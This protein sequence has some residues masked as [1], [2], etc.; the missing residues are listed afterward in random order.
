[1]GDFNSTFLSGRI[2]SVPVAGKTKKGI[3]AL[4][5]KVRVTED[6]RDEATG[7][8][9]ERETVLE[10]V[11]YGALARMAASELHAGDQIYI[12]GRNV[13]STWEQEGNVRHRVQIQVKRYSAEPAQKRKAG[14]PA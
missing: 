6:E 11:A 8:W 5:F 14:R 13:V 2:V 1:M 10:C 7:K 4:S 12:E 3:D 9:V